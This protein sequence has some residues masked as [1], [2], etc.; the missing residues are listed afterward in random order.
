MRKV[1]WFAIAMLL[2]GCS[3]AA[4]NDQAN[5]SSGGNN[6]CPLF[7]F[8]EDKAEQDGTHGIIADA[9]GVYWTR[10]GSVWRADPGGASPKVLAQGNFK[11]AY[12]LAMDDKALY[13]VDYGEQLVRVNKDGSGTMVLAKDA[14]IIGV[15]VDKDSVYYTNTEGIFRTPKDTAAAQL[16]ATLQ[17][18]GSIV[19]D[20]AYVYVRTIGNADDLSCRTVRVLKTGGNVEEIST[21]E[22]VDYHYFTHE[23]AVDETSVYWISPSPG[24]LMKAPKAGGPAVVLAKDLAD[25]VSLTRDGENL[26][27]TLHGKTDGPGTD[28]AVIR[29]PRK[30]GDVTYLVKGPEVSAFDV[31]ADASHLYWTSRVAGAGVTA[32]CK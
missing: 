4:T 25:P 31:V 17:S 2:V 8:S 20:D 11:D 24:A 27:V 6:A 30:G 12:T 5:T 21:P 10:D 23:L 19:L 32:A 22:K 3:D 18:A 7:T 16:F 9:S 26:Y 28:R 13:V 15:A 14:G 29:V 1:S